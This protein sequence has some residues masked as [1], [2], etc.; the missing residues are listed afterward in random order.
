MIELKYVE[1]KYRPT[2]RGLVS[3]SVTFR[4]GEITGIL[5]GNGSGKTSM[6]KAIMGIGEL[7]GGEILIDGKPVGEQYDRIAFITEEGSYLPHFTPA[8]YADFLADFYPN[9]NTA[10][11]DRLLQLFEL[12]PDKRIRTFSKGQRS[13]LE[14]CAGF[15]KGA[16]YILMDEPFLGKDM[17]ARRDF[18]KLMI[19]SLKGDETIL[20]S[21][22]LIEEIENVIDRAIIMR[23]GRIKGDIYIDDLRERG[24]DLTAYM[25][26]VAGYKPTR[27]KQ[28][29]G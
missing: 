18:L 22:H 25:S 10:Q 7:Q 9:F 17:F 28:I 24:G 13:K 20:L 6:L 11:F 15:S 5:G 23:E 14:I 19:A 4:Q 12:E 21:T 27:V 29:F 8:Q 3:E 1:K 2:G 26:E 16:K